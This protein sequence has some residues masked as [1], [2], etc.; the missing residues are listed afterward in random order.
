MSLHL[1]LG[2]YDMKIK[3]KKQQTTQTKNKNSDLFSTSLNSV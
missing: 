1:D 3:K 2:K